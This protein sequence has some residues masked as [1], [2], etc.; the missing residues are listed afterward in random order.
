MFMGEA[1]KLSSLSNKNNT[2][3]PII[4]FT[5]L[6]IDF[7]TNFLDICIFFTKTNKQNSHQ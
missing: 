6:Q 4:I 5:P 2:Y 7:A 1:V 3:N